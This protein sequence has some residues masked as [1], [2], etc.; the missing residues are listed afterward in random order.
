MQFEQRHL[1]REAESDSFKKKRD[2]MRETYT[3]VLAVEYEYS[4]VRIQIY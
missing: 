4:K 1:R 3:D 2:K